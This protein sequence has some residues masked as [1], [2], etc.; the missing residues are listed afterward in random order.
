MEIGWRLN[1]LKTH[2]LAIWQKVL[3]PRDYS[4]LLQENERLALD[5]GESSRAAGLIRRYSVRTT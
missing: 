4:V 1:F 3:L 5:R 2:D